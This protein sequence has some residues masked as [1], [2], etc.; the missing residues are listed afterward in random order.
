L[1][2]QKLYDDFSHPAAPFA[3]ATLLA[4]LALLTLG[5]KTY[6]EWKSRREQEPL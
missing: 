6:L 1:C 2:V 3:V 5:I 4:L